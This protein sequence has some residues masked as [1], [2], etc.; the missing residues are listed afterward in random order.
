MVQFTM[1]TNS[2]CAWTDAKDAIV[3]LNLPESANGPVVKRLDVTSIPILTYAV[4]NDT[5][6][7]KNLS[8]FVDDIIKSELLGLNGVGEVS[9]HT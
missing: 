9:P 3:G 1:E 6:S 8:H 5:R 7:I 2:D 4:S